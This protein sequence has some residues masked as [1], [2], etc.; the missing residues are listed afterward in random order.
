[1]NHSK[2]LRLSSMLTIFALVLAACGGAAP[3][4]TEASGGEA[5]GGL[6]CKGAAEG[7][8]VSILYQW[9]GAEEETF[10][11]AIA[12][13]V[14]AC[15]L[16]IVPESSRDQALL[17]TRISS[18][19]PWDIVIWPTTGPVSSYSDSLVSAEEA[20]ADGSNYADFWK[21]LGSANDTWYGIP[22]KADVKSIVWYSPV[23]FEANGYSVP[24]TWDEF[25]AL[26]DQMVADGN[27]PFSMGFESGDAT[28][29]TASDFIQDILLTT[30][31]PDYVYGLLDGSISYDDAGVAEA[32]EIY[33]NWATDPAYAVGGAEGSLSTGFLDAIYKPF[34]DPAEAMMVKQSGFAGAE[35][36]AQFPELEFGTDFDFFGFPG[37]Q[38]IQGGSDWMM[39]FNASPAAQAVVAYLTSAE[40]GAHWASVGFGLSPNNGALGNYSDPINAKLAEVLAGASGSTPDIGDSIQ[41]SFGSAEWTAI[42]DVIS[43][44]STI[45]AAL[46]QAAAA[47]AA[48]LAQ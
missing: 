10:N 16:V 19:D 18:G 31:G 47:Q 44:A 25:S 37:A 13:I 11:A 14:E 42:V 7:D 17:E 1:M 8:E 46:A 21:D 20:G 43:G 32:Y 35:V 2:M 3:A 6:D 48:D 26:A 39:V 45:E 38:G 5:T 24:T 41:P 36:K 30:Q 22:V 4:A 15:G 34:G 40:G 27:V 23:A 28:G 29:W 9:A 33:S 12:P